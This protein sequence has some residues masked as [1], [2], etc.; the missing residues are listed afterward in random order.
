MQRRKMKEE[1]GKRKEES[2]AETMRRHEMQGFSANYTEDTERTEETEI[3]HYMAW[4]EITGIFAN[5][6]RTSRTGRISASQND[7]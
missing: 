5:F 7:I 6:C 4:R 2:R 3:A 1:R